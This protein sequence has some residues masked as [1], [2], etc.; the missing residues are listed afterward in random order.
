LLERLPPSVARQLPLQCF[1][2][3][4]PSGKPSL[5]NPEGAVL[6]GRPQ[7]AVPIRVLVH[8]VLLSLLEVEGAIAAEGIPEHSVTGEGVAAPDAPH[9]FGL[10]Q[11]EF[12]AGETQFVAAQ[13]DILGELPALHRPGAVLL[14]LLEAQRF[15][16]L[17]A[18]LRGFGSPE[19]QISV[20]LSAALFTLQSLLVDLVRS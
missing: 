16:S 1:G 3:S 18:P 7:V 2:S 10:P 15:P 13:A 5:V 19:A 4:E 11:A 17:L 20:E 6:Q 14:T 9:R 12:V 8:D